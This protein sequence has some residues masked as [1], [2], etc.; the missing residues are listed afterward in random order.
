MRYFLFLK[1]VAPHF[2]EPRLLCSFVGL[3][4]FLP[5]CWCFSHL[6]GLG[7]LCSG[8][9]GCFCSELLLPA[10]GERGAPEPGRQKLGSLLGAVLTS[11]CWVL[12][13][14]TS[15]LLS[16]LCRA[17]CGF[18]VRYAHVWVMS[19]TASLGLL[20]AFSAKDRA[21][22][23]LSWGSSAHSACLSH[24]ILYQAFC[25]NWSTL[26]ICHMCKPLIQWLL[27]EFLRMFKGK[28]CSLKNYS[29]CWGK[30]V[31]DC[32]EVFTRA[33][34]L[35]SAWVPRAWQVSQ[36]Q[37]EY[38]DRDSDLLLSSGHALTVCRQIFLG[39]LCFGGSA[40][41]KSR[42]NSKRYL[43]VDGKYSES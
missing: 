8:S 43:Y 12:R 29:S 34:K 16:V 13:A 22:C 14:G 30:T 17:L 41:T 1:R 25:N 31:T 6:P 37:F 33:K 11:S 32:Q 15:P 10:L 38:V 27:Y 4:L 24:G 21:S 42:N 35:G 40:H 18:Q 28:S 36:T 23:Q 39:Y 19:C 9:Y 7:H 20:L 26:S 5:G 2:P 3:Y